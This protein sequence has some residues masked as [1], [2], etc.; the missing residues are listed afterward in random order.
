MSHSLSARTLLWDATQSPVLVCPPFVE[1]VVYLWPASRST[2]NTCTSTDS[3]GCRCFREFSHGCR[4]L[5]AL[6]TCSCQVAAVLLSHS[7]QISSSSGHLSLLAGI[8]T[9]CCSVRGCH[10]LQLPVLPYIAQITPPVSPYSTFR[11]LC[12]VHWRFGCDWLLEQAPLP[13]GLV[14]RSDIVRL[15]YH[16]YSVSLG[17]HSPAA[18]DH[19]PHRPVAIM[20]CSRV[21]RFCSRI[22]L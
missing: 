17:S 1:P 14:L 16:K 8:S 15:H 7:D 9:C 3:Q 2:A 10:L 21:L 4:A 12:A 5:L 20:R 11:P 22:P 19:I 18:I 6:R 13:E